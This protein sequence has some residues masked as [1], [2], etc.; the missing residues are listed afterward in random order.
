MKQFSESESYV[1]ADQPV[2]PIRDMLARRAIQLRVVTG[3][4]NE[5]AAAEL[6]TSPGFIE[7]VEAD[8]VARG[9]LSIETMQ[10][11][12]SAKRWGDLEASCAIERVFQ[13]DLRPSANVR[14]P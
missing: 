12:A 10:V 11:V 1:P 5:Q 14:R 8:F 4:T 3:M 2:S 7:A 13:R 9:C 6:G